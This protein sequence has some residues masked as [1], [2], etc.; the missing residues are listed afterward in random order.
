MVTTSDL[1]HKRWLAECFDSIIDLDA[2]EDEINAAIVHQAKIQRAVRAMLDGS[3]SL[4]DMLESVED[5]VPSMDDYM[6]EVTENLED[7]QLIQ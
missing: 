3:L 5:C 6:N 2:Y 7:F 4:K 1:L